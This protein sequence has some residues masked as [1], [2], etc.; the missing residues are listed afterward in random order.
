MTE[1]EVNWAEWSRKPA[2]L[3]PGEP[4]LSLE[5]YQRLEALKL[6]VQIESAT[7]QSARLTH[8]DAD[9]MVVN[10]ET[11]FQYLKEGKQS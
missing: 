9:G 6:A 3:V 11:F 10:A 1:I 2:M 8:I 4:V 5:Q 7:R